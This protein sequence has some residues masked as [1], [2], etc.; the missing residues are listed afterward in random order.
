MRV[1]NRLVGVVAASV[2]AA[3]ALEAQAC[4]GYPS[5]GGGGKNV[6]AQAYLPDGATTVLGQF[7]LGKDNGNFGGLQLGFTSIDGA[8]VTPLT[9]GGVA[10]IER[11]TG[12]VSWCPLATAQYRTEFEDINLAGGISAA[13]DIFSAGSFTLAPFAS[14]RLNYFMPDI[15]DNDS[16]LLYGLG[17]AFR[18]NNGIVLAPSL[19]FSS[20]SGADEV[21]GLRVSLPLGGR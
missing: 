9:V 19:D 8:D 21:L 4:M 11:T 10:G 3:G 5:F 7:N 16:F 14:A 15:G 17:V 12:K 6:S 1:V 13:V 18:L 2:L 20:Q